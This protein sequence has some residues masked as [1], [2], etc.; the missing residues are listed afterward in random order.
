M[1]SQAI[2]LPLTSHAAAAWLRQ[3]GILLALTVLSVGLHAMKWAGKP[4]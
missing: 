2:R 1:K 4:L 3:S